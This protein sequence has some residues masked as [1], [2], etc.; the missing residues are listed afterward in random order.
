[1][2]AVVDTAYAQNSSSGL[3]SALIQQAPSIMVVFALYAN[4]F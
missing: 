3:E 4:S 2:G 1:M